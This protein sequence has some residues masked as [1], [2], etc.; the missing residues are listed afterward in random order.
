MPPKKLTEAQKRHKEV[1]DCM[2][3]VIDDSTPPG[4]TSKKYGFSKSMIA[5]AKKTG[6][7][8]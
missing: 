1:A 6:Y 2:S 4:K 3:E 8:I 7:K 5:R